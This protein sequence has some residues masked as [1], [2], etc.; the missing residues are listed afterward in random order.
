M[1]ETPLEGGL[2]ADLPGLRGRLMPEAPLKD[3][4]WFRVGG[5]AEVLYSPADEAD[6]ALFLECDCRTKSP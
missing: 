1:N 6:L 3:L 4:T 2:A 5:P